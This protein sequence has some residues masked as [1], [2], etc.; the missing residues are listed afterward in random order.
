MR[1]MAAPSMLR[2]RRGRGRRYE[3]APVQPIEVGAE[4]TDHIKALLID[5][6]VYGGIAAAM[7]ALWGAVDAMI[8]GLAAVFLRAARR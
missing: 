3:E 4:M 7:I 1:T 5:V 2:R 6:G 8:I